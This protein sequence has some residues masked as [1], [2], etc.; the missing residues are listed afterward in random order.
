[1]VWSNLTAFFILVVTGTLLFSHH[2]TVRT[3]ADTAR[4]L[5]PF[6]GPYA[7]YLF[8][9]GILGAGLLAIPVLA[10]STAYS[11]AAL[12]GWR[13]SLSRHV[14]NA[15]QF[16]VVL[17]AALLTAVQLAVMGV[18]PLQALFYSQV[19]D[20]LIAPLL[21]VLLLLLTS[22][23]R[24]MRDFANRL[25]TKIIGWVAIAVLVAADT[26]MVYSVVTQ[27]LPG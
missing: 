23:R 26:A 1:M 2:Q 8:A 13:R 20:G 3:A 14:N 19:L 22:S 9:V 7:K 24:V 21:V 15:P 12:F 18:N 6:T 4:A 5:E 16:Y 17:G 27:G 25:P 11:V 10:A